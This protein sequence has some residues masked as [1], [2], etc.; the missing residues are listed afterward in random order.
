MN[1]V[2]STEENVW[3]SA[4]RG[5]PSWCSFKLLHALFQPPKIGGVDS[6]SVVW[7]CTQSFDQYVHR[8]VHIPR[9]VLEVRA[10]SKVCSR[11]TC[12]YLGTYLIHK[13][14]KFRGCLEAVQRLFRGCLEAASEPTNVPISSAHTWTPFHHPLIFAINIGSSLI[15]E[16]FKR[17]YFSNF[18]GRILIQKLMVFKF[19]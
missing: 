9:S 10:S 17:K 14:I 5:K 2:R 15:S 19:L 3:E 13:F 1:A 4:L 12:T 11:G 8:Y 16:S 6:R 18:R 7:A